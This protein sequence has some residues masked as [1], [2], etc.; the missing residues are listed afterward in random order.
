MLEMVV[1]LV[2]IL[3]CVN[4][5]WPKASH[6]RNSLFWLTVPKGE[7]IIAG[8]TWHAG[9]KRRLA[10]YISVHTQEA[11]RGSRKQVVL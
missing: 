6:R 2:I 5:Q 10:R 7:S 9:R 3:G 4:I 1:V 8:K 11:E